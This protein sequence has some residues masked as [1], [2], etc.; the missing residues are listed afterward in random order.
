MVTNIAEITHID[1]RLTLC[2]A[3]VN[4]LFIQTDLLPGFDKS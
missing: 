3:Q 4:S 1:M 2:E